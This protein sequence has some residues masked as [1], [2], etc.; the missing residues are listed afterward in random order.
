M[1]VYL[2][3]NRYRA[4]FSL[5]GQ[6]FQIYCK[7]KEEASLL[8]DLATELKQKTSPPWVIRNT[9]KRSNATKDLPIGLIDSSEVRKGQRHTYIRCV[10]DDGKT[11]TRRYGSLRSREMA[12][13]EV[14]QAAISHYD[15][16]RPEQ[17]LW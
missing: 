16:K 14:F 7:K 8:C 4:A 6:P 9:K 13:A 5:Y 2:Y 1:G 11:I 17:P 10:M 3:N 12:I 15:S